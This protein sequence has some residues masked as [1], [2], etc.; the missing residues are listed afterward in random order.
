M[1]QRRMCVCLRYSLY[2]SSLSYFFVIERL[3]KS[4]EAGTSDAGQFDRGST[5]LIALTFSFNIT[6]FI[7]TNVF[8]YFQIGV[9]NDIIGW[10]GI[11]I[12]LY[13]IKLWVQALKTLRKFYTRTLRVTESHNV[14]QEGPYKKV[15]HTE[16]LG[17]ILMLVGAGL[18]TVNWIAAVIVR[19]TTTIAAHRY[20][21]NGEKLY[22]L[23]LLVTSRENI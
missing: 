9:A 10:V 2:T 4:Q 21:I 12:M 14:V 17:V 8:N 23:R 7:A 22:L 6:V 18:P 1:G 15:R 3:R 19:L 16:Y 5:R 13:G 11:V 20:R